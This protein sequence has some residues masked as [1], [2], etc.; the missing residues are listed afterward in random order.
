MERN[1][2]PIF[3]EN[4]SGDIEDNEGDLD[5]LKSNEQ[6]PI[7]LNQTTGEET[8]DDQRPV[9]RP[10]LQSQ[11]GS[12]RESTYAAASAEPYPEAGSEG[13]VAISN[14]TSSDATGNHEDSLDHGSDANSPSDD[15]C[16]YGDGNGTIDEQ[17][18][19]TSILST[20]PP[21][22]SSNQPEIE[23]SRQRDMDR[24]NNIRQLSGREGT[25]E[26]F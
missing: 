7:Q 14:T 4:T 26:Q 5:I 21:P 8:E 25:D 2:Q 20:L 15:Y 17:L 22:T 16:I 19:S 23:E 18:P 12:D 9:K 6:N 1:G 24:H 3:I 10:K 11:L 13:P